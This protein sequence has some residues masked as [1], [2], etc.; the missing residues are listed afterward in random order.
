MNP[1][2]RATERLDAVEGKAKDAEHDYETAR[3]TAMRAGKAFEEVKEQRLEA[4]N[5]AFTHISGAIGDGFSN[6]GFGQSQSSTHS[7]S[8]SNG[9]PGTSV[10]QD[11]NVGSSFGGVGTQSGS[12]SGSQSG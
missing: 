11:I 5:K 8:F 4:F 12:S 3:K 9:N 7:D 6:S 1:N 10:F 2:M